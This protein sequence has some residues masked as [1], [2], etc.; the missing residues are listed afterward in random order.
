MTSMTNETTP[1][2]EGIGPERIGNA[3]KGAVNTHWYHLQ[4]WRAVAME[5]RAD[6]KALLSDVKDYHTK[7][8]KLTADIAMLREQLETRRTRS[9][10]ASILLTLTG[11]CSGFALFLFPRTPNPGIEGSGNQGPYVPASLFGITAFVLL[12][13]AWILSIGPFKK[14]GS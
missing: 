10:I 14:R 6:N 1:E 11:I 2:P 9:I 12:V 7:E 3:P 5:A 13:F 8:V 4:Q